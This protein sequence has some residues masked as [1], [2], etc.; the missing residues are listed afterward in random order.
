M[1]L[2]DLCDEMFSY[3]KTSQMDKLQSEAFGQLPEPVVL[4]RRAFQAHMAGRCNHLP[5][6]R[7]A[8][9]VSAVGIIPYPP[10]IPIVMPGERFG[11]DDQPWL[12]YIRSIAEWG[13]KFPGFE[14]E[15]EGAEMI[16][17][18]YHIWVLEP[19]AG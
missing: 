8:G 15:L 7:L 14:K 9:R 16:D 11:R 3:M 6:G 12:R 4:P 17:G 2:K 5:L 10:G 1:G 19:D 18:T 13:E